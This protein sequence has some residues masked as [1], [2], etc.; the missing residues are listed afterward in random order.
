MSSFM[1]Y[2][3]DRFIVTEGS[4]LQ[5]YNYF[6]S[7]RLNNCSI[8]EQGC[9]DLSAALCC[10]PSHLTALDLSGNKLG[11]SGVKE[12]SQLLKNSN[13]KL[14][15][16]NLSDCSVS[17]KGYAALDS[18][19]KSNTSSHLIELDL[20]GNDP[21]NTGV[22]S[23]HYYLQDPNYK[24]K[25]LRLLKTPAAEKACASLS[26]ALGMNVLLQTELNLSRNPAGLSG[27]S[28]VKLLCDLLQDT[29]CKLRKLQINN[30]D[31]TEESCSALATVLTSSSLRE[32]DLSNNNLQN[33]GVKKL[34][35]ALKNPL[36]KLETLS[37]STCSVTGEGYAALTS[38]LT[39]NRDSHLKK[40]D[41]SGNDPGDKG[42]E[43]ITSVF[44]RSNKTLSITERGCAALSAALCSNPSHLTVLD[45]SGNKLGDS[46]VKEI[47]H[48]L[49][50]SNSKLELINNDDLTEESCSA[51]ATVLTSSSLREL[52]LSN[53][54]LQDSGVKKLCEAL[55]DPLCKLETL[56]FITFLIYIQFLKQF[57]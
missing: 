10:N 38:A 7:Y 29:H 49:K 12:I 55:K 30:D 37:L 52:D 54:N 26:A 51:L 32:L 25:T 18:A 34:C 48:L 19:L 56:R 3:M 8:T 20:R 31:L 42:V 16:L 2:E 22:K 13:S 35:E 11:D 57:T 43:L 28:R 23:L 46:G 6:F 41:F 27:D 9:S 40:L 33:S 45:L 47:S 44:I 36:C 15:L 21:G 24:L 1:H 53:N 4:I 50:N 39:T 17:E 5:C 14:E